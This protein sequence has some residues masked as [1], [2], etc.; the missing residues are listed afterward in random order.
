M[1]PSELKFLIKH[2]NSISIEMILR[3]YQLL[4]LGQEGVIGEKVNFVFIVF[5]T[6]DAIV[7]FQNYPQKMS[8]VRV[9]SVN[10]FRFF[11][12]LFEG[13]KIHSNVQKKIFSVSKRRLLQFFVHRLVFERCTLHNFFRFYKMVEHGSISKNHFPPLFFHYCTIQIMCIQ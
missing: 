2:S 13:E 3:E 1:P 8:L 12:P 11:T 7:N 10:F 9:T 5:L 6:T 4:I